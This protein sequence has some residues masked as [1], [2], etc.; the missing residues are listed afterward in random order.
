MWNFEKFKD[1]STD[2]YPSIF[3]PWIMECIT[4]IVVTTVGTALIFNY[5][6]SKGIL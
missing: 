3:W 2:G 5:L 4:I 6:K 1:Y